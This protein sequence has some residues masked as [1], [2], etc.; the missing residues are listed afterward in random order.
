LHS[1]NDS[2]GFEHT[3]QFCCQTWIIGPQTFDPLDS[4]N[5][6]QKRGFDC[7]LMTLTRFTEF[8]NC[9]LVRYWLGTPSC[10]QKLARISVLQGLKGIHSQSSNCRNSWLSLNLS[11]A[12]RVFAIHFPSIP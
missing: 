3:H 11:S 9:E 4:Y 1:L 5:R 6:H 2:P 10:S 8:P 7:P 12:S